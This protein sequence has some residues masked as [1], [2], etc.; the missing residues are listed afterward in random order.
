VDRETIDVYNAGAARWQAQRE[1]QRTALAAELAAK[2]ATTSNPAHTTPGPLL[3]LGC[4]PGGHLAALGENVVG[5]DASMPMLQLARQAGPHAPLMVG[6]IDALPV[7]P[8]SLGGVWA[9][10][11]LVHVPRSAVPLALAQLHRSMQLDAPLRLLVFA[12]DAEHDTFA[13]DDFPG[14]RFSLW[15]EHLLRDVVEGAGFQIDTVQTESPWSDKGSDTLVVVARAAHSLADT[16]GAGMRVLMVGLNPSPASSDAAVGFARPGNRFWPAALG[17]SLVSRDRDPWHALH[18]HGVGM[19]DLVKRTTR[20]AAEVSKAE[21]AEGA[22][23]VERIVRWLR[24]EVVCFVGLS[25]YRHAINNRA[26]AGVVPGGFG[27]A[28]AYVMPSTSGLNAHETVASLTDHL[29]AVRELSNTGQ[30]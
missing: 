13:H 26:V 12:G 16:V 22:E 18:G 10:K 17:A 9:S 14:R 5:L 6:D 2:V 30:P 27:G 8:R 29:V 4:G 11:S 28:S 1:T 3:D 20:K 21:F 25:G 19:T 7:A 15:P 23:R 24:P